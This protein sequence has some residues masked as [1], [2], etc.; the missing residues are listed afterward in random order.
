MCHDRAHERCWAF[1]H[2]KP[3]AWRPTK[4]HTRLRISLLPRM[5]QSNR[6][7]SSTRRGGCSVRVRLALL[8]SSFFTVQLVDSNG[9][10]V[11]SMAHNM[12]CTASFAP[13]QTFILPWGDLNAHALFLYSFRCAKCG[14]QLSVSVSGHVPLPN[15]KPHCVH[16]FRHSRPSYS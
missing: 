4:S 15:Q 12:V 10:K 1:G 7:R 5:P 8:N 2:A 9:P 14:D 13:I 16:H 6:F 11:V 3:D